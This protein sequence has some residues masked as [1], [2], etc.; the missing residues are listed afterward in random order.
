M[1]K[2]KNQGNSSKYI[3]TFVL[4]G[5]KENKGIHISVAGG[6]FNQKRS[7]RYKIKVTYKTLHIFAHY[8]GLEIVSTPIHA[9]IVRLV[10]ILL[11]S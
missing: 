3:R 6:Y 2:V 5:I 9:S 11:C 8:L 10:G 4:M 7:N 1:K